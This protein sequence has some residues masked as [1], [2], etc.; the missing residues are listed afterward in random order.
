MV[1]LRSALERRVNPMS[2]PERQSGGC[3]PRPPLSKF[4]N[5]APQLFAKRPISRFGAPRSAPA[6]AGGRFH[7][8]I[9]GNSPNCLRLPSVGRLGAARPGLPEFGLARLYNRPPR[10]TLCLINDNYIL[11]HLAYFG[12]YIKLRFAY[13]LAF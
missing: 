9:G 13:A 4:R 3:C 1:V 8:P 2:A 5:S 7:R 12:K 11:F 6:M 10:Q